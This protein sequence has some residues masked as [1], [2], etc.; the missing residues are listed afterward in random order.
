RRKLHVTV[1]LKALG[2]S[3]EE[4]LQ[5]FYDHEVIQLGKGGKL[6][7]N[8]DTKLYAG[9]RAN[10]DW[11]G[12]DG[13]VVVEKNKKFTNAVLK[14]ID[15]AKIR[16]FPIEREQVIGKICAQDVVDLETG[17]VLLECN[18]EISDEKIDRLIDRNI[19]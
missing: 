9:Q 7:L 1:L 14:R 12:E 18:E 19:S 5:Y 11:V 4:L 8:F 13:K 6:F 10:N 17:E 16:R 15:E 3:V 2:Y